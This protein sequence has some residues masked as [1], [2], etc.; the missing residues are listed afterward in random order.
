MQK[1]HRSFVCY[2]SIFF[3]PAA[4][5]GGMLQ[6][7]K[8]EFIQH[9]KGYSGAGRERDQIKITLLDSCFTKNIYI[10]SY[11][12]TFEF[13]HVS[14]DHNLKIIEIQINTLVLHL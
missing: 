11:F 1:K 5:C 4:F 6:L 9:T 10:I 7:F 12:G 14:I 8:E 13:T 3:F 2:D